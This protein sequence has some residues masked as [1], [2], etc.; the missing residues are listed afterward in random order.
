MT[1]AYEL[2]EMTKF[3]K[4]RVSGSRQTLQGKNLKQN[5]AQSARAESTH[6]GVNQRSKDVTQ[7]QPTSEDVPLVDSSLRTLYKHLQA[8]HVRVTVDDSGFCCCACVMA[9]ER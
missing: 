1:E 5:E 8:C 6:K 3:P 2:A 4:S 9:F 7:T